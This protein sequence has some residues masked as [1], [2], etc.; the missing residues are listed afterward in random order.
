MA[1][2]RVRARTIDLL[3]RQQIASIS[4]AISELFKNAHDAYASNVE[5]DYFRD[6]GLFVLRDDG[7]GMTKKD[8]LDRWLTLGTDSKVSAAAGLKPPPIDPKKDKRPVLGEKGIGRLAIAV[9]GRQLLVLT[10]AK[11]NGVP[12]G[13]LTAAYLHWGMFELPGIGLDEIA[14]PVETYSADQLPDKDDVQELIEVAR[15][16]LKDLSSKIEGSVYKVIKED[17]DTFDVDPRDASTYLPEPSFKGEGCGTHF[18]IQPADKI[19]HDDIDTREDQNKATRFEKNLIG[20]TNTMTPHAKKP[21]IITKFRDY[22]DEGTPIER[23]GDQEFFTPDD[24]QNC[25][26]HI[27]GKFDAFGQFSG[28]VSV[29]HMQPTPYVLNWKNTDGKPTGCG[30]FKF[31]LAVMQG[32]KSDTLLEPSQHLEIS[33]KLNRHGGVYIYKDAIRIQPYGGPGHDFLELERRRSTRASTFFY[34]FRNIM[35]AVELNTKNNSNLVEKAGRE[36]FREDKSYRQFQEILV[37][38]MVQSAADFFVADGKYSDDWEDKREELNALEAVRRKRSKQSSKKKNVFA[39]ELDKFFTRADDMYFENEAEIISAAFEAEI[40][41]VIQSEKSNLNKGLAVGNLERVYQ[42]KTEKLRKEITL[43][44]PRGVGFGKSALNQWKSYQAEN[45]KILN[46]VV[47]PLEHKIGRTVSKAVKENKLDLSPSRR[48]D[49]AI[50]KY[51]TETLRNIGSDR[52][53]VKE[54]LTD[55]TRIVREYTKESF[56]NVSV[57]VD[58]VRAELERIKSKTQS[59]LDFSKAKLD[60]ENQIDV[61]FSEEHEKLQKITTQ[62]ASVYAYANSKDSDLVEVAEALEEENIALRERQEVD[63]ELAQIGMA[64][65]TINHEFGKTASGLRDGFRRLKAWSDENPNMIELY[66]DMRTSFE[67]LDNYLSMFNPLD[68]RLQR[69]ATDISGKEIHRFLSDLFEKRLERHNVSLKVSTEFKEVSIRG[70]QSDYYPVFVNLID[71]AIYWAGLKDND[72]GLIELLCDGEDMLIRD[73][74]IGVSKRDVNNIFEMNFS[75]KPGGRGMGLHISMQ[76]LKRLGYSLTLDDA[77]YNQG[78]TFRI[79]KLSDLKD[80]L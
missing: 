79:S 42:D 28:K 34:S 6:D 56:R 30:P 14:I 20:F 8:F 21:K 48:L 5:V 63:F 43:S 37:N 71:N 10:R 12:E 19:L 78:A 66:T 33:R 40:L 17:M 45:E 3:G 70:F 73:N 65:N 58:D 39:T 59:D 27:V 1:N 51:T 46:T 62:L 57:V 72:E 25:D 18:Y 64:L 9:I 49:A 13:E 7:L 22:V 76:A 32:N 80:N 23:V 68:R 61:V 74:G 26:H 11:V 15:S 4:T 52:K 54:T 77:A 55:L 69:N 2:F 41:K 44:K 50:S 75:R 53:Q 38:F 29:Y 60:F 16:N 47:R 67:H 24:Y 31:S 35:A 36:G